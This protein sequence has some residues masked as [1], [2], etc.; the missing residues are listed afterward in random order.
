MAVEEPLGASVEAVQA[1]APDEATSGTGGLAA[2]VAER[3]AKR[4]AVRELGEDPYPSR[5]DRTHTA[6][7]VHGEHPDLAPDSRTGEHVAVAGRVVSVRGHGKLSFATVRD[8]TGPIQLMLAIDRLEPPSH[9]VLAQLDVGDWVG[10]AGE[11]VTTRKGE[12]SVDVTELRLLSKALRPIPSSWY[13]VSDPETRYRQREVDLWAN[14]GVRETFLLRSRVVRAL[15]QNLDGRGFVEV[16]TPMLWT[17]TPEG[18][19][20]SSSRRPAVRSHVLSSPGPMHS[21]ST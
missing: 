6:A 9:E 13:G 21:I 1:D 16:E 12:L 3:R 19:R 7:A 5:Y 20:R 15:R 4:E 10:A 14:E 18:A 17:P 11:V 2:Q 8:W